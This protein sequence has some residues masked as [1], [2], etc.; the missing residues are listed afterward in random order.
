MALPHNSGC[1][2][3]FTGKVAESGKP[4]TNCSSES[5]FHQIEHFVRHFEAIS[6]RYHSRKNSWGFIGR[7]N[8]SSK[9]SLSGLSRNL[10]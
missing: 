8:R 3:Y 5:H 1:L 4:H 10:K 7:V 6:G 9:G 2:A